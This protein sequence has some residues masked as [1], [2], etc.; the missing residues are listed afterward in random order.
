MTPAFR[1]LWAAQSA[2]DVGSYLSLVALPLVA[3]VQLD[4]SPTQMGLLVGA[5]TAPLAFAWPLLGVLADRVDRGRMMVV[6]YLGRALL[7]GWIPVA[8]ATGV[9]TIAQLAV[10]SFL[11]NLFKVAFDVAHPSV[12]PA[13]VAPADLVAANS[14]LE[15]TRSLAMVAGPAAA[16]LLVDAVRPTGVMAFEAVACLLAGLLVGT[17]RTP[18]PPPRRTGLARD[19]REGVTAVFGHPLLRAMAISTALLNAFFALRT[20]LFALFVV[21]EL[22]FSASRL[23]LVLAA[24]GPGALIGSLAAPR[25]A[26]RWG[27]GRTSTGAAFA[28][29]APVLAVP[30]VHGSGTGAMAVLMASAFA[31]GFGAQVYNVTLVAGRQA[32]TPDHLLG[33]MTAT[34]RWAAWAAT[35]FAAAG[36]GLLAAVAGVRGAIAV[37]GLGLLLPGL[38]L[39]LAGLP[40]SSELTAHGSLAAPDPAP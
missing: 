33:R 4:A 12:V 1:R 2:S 36:G 3:V 40:A 5:G 38:C 32:I 18:A 29:G 8:A 31:V 11:A 27:F 35:P 13:V 10:V 25:V 15:S 17:V 14:R 22:G 20:P 7:F 26:A 30:L 6:S 23:G 37:A 28:A 21:A 19:L 39:L 24:A 34:F 16:G 9:L